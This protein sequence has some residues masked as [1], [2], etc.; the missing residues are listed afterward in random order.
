MKNV[1]VTDLDGTLLDAEGRLSQVSRDL[2][3]DAIDRGVHF[4]IASARG[5]DSIRA[6]I[7]DLP[8]RL[9]IIEFNGSYI[10][11]YHTGEKL[12]VNSIAPEMNRVIHETITA[13]GLEMIVTCHQEGHDVLHYHY[14]ALSAG[15]RDYVDYR[16]ANGDRRLMDGE[17]MRRVI[18]EEIICFNA[19]DT[20]ERITRVHD[21]LIQAFGDRLE[22]HMMKGTYS[23]EWYW[24]NVADPEGTKGQALKRFR[25]RYLAA[26]DILYVFGDNNNDI[27]MFEVADRPVAL[28]NSVDKLK[29]LAGEIIGYNYEDSVARYVHGKAAM[30]LE[31]N[32]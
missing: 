10:T 26:E 3:V 14:A 30:R 27:G 1:F 21:T 28:E 6:V 7:K 8:L 24:L 19:I 18:P 9:P 29:A 16:L 12:H 11:D 17:D 13:G 5:I 15:A 2:L 22:V 23:D 31:K 4:T 20:K 32:R 25:E